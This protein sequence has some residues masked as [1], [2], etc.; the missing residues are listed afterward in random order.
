MC[1]FVKKFQNL[2]NKHKLLNKNSLFSFH[3]VGKQLL[4][5]Q[6]KYN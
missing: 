6:S 5:D 3:R 4:S 1:R 2:I